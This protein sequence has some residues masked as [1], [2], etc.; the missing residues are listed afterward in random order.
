[1]IQALMLLP[2]AAGVLAFLVRSDAARRALLVWT[3]RAHFLLSA[4]LIWL[5]TGPVPLV[6]TCVSPV[7]ASAPAEV[8]FDY[9]PLGLLFLG[10]TSL[11]FLGAAHY[12][13]AY[14]AAEKRDP[15]EDADEGFI[16][17]NA[18]EAAFTGCLL[19]FLAAM[20]AVTAS[21]HMGLLWACVEATT[22]LSAPLIYFHRHKRSLEATWKYLLICSVGIALALMGNLFLGAAGLKTGAGL[23]LGALLAK[24]AAL[25]K[26]LLKAAFLFLF[27]GY[28][29]KMGL[30]PF[31]TWLPDAHS[32][33]PAVV[34]ALLSGALLNC[35]FLG[36]LR[37]NSVCARAGLADF[38]GGILVLF[39]LFSLVTAALFM[40]GQRDYKRMLAYSSIEHMGILAIGA[41]LGGAA[42]FGAMLG[43]FSHSLTKAG[44]FF[45]SG[46]VLASEK[47]KRI[48]DVR[49]LWRLAPRTA[50]LWLGGF[51]I[52]TGTPPFG[53][54]LAKFL[55]LREALARGHYWLAAAYLFFLALLF[56]G[57]AKVFIAMTF[58]E[59]AEK[60]GD[61]PFAEP[62]GMLLPAAVLF[63]VVLLAGL[64]L[65]GWFSGLLRDAAANVAGTL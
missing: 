61:R 56:A 14:L 51:F 26:P 60:P 38:T 8:W 65:P 29:T 3:A 62:R 41:G 4:A 34:S 24:G 59:C 58:G 9:D 43:A 28:G 52:I 55:I 13:V 7:P 32:E 10:I 31:H 64:Y 37:V 36:I 42:L 17:N 12:A 35:A 57:M 46:V 2:L 47:T 33:A 16:F 44:L 39:G 5:K 40:L 49:G 21:R 22:L 20:T 53:V 15:G 18:P 30:S 1:M 54:F 45:T 19:L 23:D 25:D 63:A 27:V 6:L 11:L 48:S 50:A